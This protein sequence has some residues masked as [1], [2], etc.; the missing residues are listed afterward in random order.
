MPISLA[1]S[2]AKEAFWSKALE[3][4]TALHNNILDH[5]RTSIDK[6]IRIGELLAGI[7]NELNHGQWLPWLGDYVSFSERT[8]Q[9]YLF[10]FDNREK[11]KNDNVTD[12]TD[13]YSLLLLRDRNKSDQ[14]QQ[15]HEPNF[16]SQFTGFKQKAIGLFNHWI[17]RRPLS[18]WHTV[19]LFDTLA[20]VEP[21]LTV[22]DAIKEELSKRPDAPRS[23]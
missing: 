6:A 9:R 19:E 22:R 21:W 18:H 5:A 12:L 3:E 16:H 11:I 4:I 13:A 20:S 14:P 17:Q 23:Y 8:A 10:C 7:K 15:L 2:P 1:E